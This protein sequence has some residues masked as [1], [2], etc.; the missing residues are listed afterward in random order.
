MNIS[1][2][3]DKDTLW[4]DLLVVA[5]GPAVLL[6]PFLFK[7]FHV[8]DPLFVWTAQRI[9]EHPTDFYG[10]ITNWSRQETF[11]WE[12][13]QNP[14]VLS[15]YLAPF[16]AAFGWSEATMHLAMLPLTVMASTGIYMAA[17]H[18]CN[19]PLLAAGVALLTPG[20]LV[21]ASQ[22]MSDI[23]MIGCWAWAL[24]CWVRGVREERE[25]LC[26]LGAFIIGAGALTKYFCFSLAPLLFVFTL[27]EKP[28]RW[29]LPLLPAHSPR[30][31]DG[32]RVS[33]TPAIRRG[34]P[35][36]RGEIRR[37]ATRNGKR[38]G[39]SQVAGDAPRTWA[40]RSPRVFFSHRC[41]GAVACWPLGQVRLVCSWCSICWRL[42]AIGS[43]AAY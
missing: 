10:Y 43:C 5:V 31:D 27:M 23:P 38:R 29:E 32:V 26:V 39:I 40:L 34:A 11:M 4:R 13:M 41:C 20:F 21:S 19:R 36:G 18:F 15:Y 3:S 17:R 8:D 7:A 42:P 24:Y 6:L 37:R 33:V 1:S 30:H 22:V 14:P 25:W 12:I 35:G 16:G 9:L 2:A 28:Q